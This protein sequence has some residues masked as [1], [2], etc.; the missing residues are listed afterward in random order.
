MAYINKINVD[1]VEYEVQDK[2]ALPSADLPKAINT[3]LAQAKES[4]GFDGAQGPAGNDYVLT[5]A[6]KQ[7][8]A[9][10]TAELVPSGGGG[11]A[12]KWKLLKTITLAE[13]TKYI[14]FDKDDDGNP[15]DCQEFFVHTSA[16]NIS[17]DTNALTIH[18]RV[19]GDLMDINS[20]NNALAI[21][22][23]KSGENGRAW[24]YVQSINPLIAFTSPFITTGT[25][26][27]KTV[28]VTNHSVG[29]SGNPFEVGGKVNHLRLVAASSASSIAAG[30][31][32]EIYGR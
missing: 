17:S 25:V 13:D 20:T 7:E 10:L 11:G 28:T 19:N 2:N 24:L 27:A 3:A 6:D 14:E 23:G 30:S 4:G 1:G 9:E 18:V 29:V 22:C 31:V 21:V 15:L 16:R 26:T 32:F 5:E 8:I 12:S